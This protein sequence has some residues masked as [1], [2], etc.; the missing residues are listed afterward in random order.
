MRFISVMF[1]FSMEKSRTKRNNIRNCVHTIKVLHDICNNTD[2]DNDKSD[3]ADN[4]PFIVSPKVVEPLFQGLILD[5]FTFFFE[6]IH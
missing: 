3:T 4:P 1:T 2:G 6:F 5:I